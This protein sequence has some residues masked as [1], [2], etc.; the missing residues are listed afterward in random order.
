MHIVWQKIFSGKKLMNQICGNK[1]CKEKPELN[2]KAS[3]QL[4]FSFFLF[5]FFLKTSIG[6]FRNWTF[7]AYFKQLPKSLYFKFA[8]KFNLL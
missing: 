3:F 5:P 6:N 4:I 1:F 7:H 8:A 2:L